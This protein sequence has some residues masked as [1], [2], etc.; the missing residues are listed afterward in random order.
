[1][2]LAVVTI[3]VFLALMSVSLTVVFALRSR[4]ATA[5]EGQVSLRRTR[6]VYDQTAPASVTGRLDRSFDRLV[7]ESGLGLT[8]VTAMLIALTA[9][10]LVGGLLLVIRGD[11]AFGAVGGLIGMLLPIGFFSFKR[12]RRMR[13]MEDQLPDAIDT[14]ARAVHAGETLEE[15]IS[16]VATE[17]IDPLKA[18][19]LWCCRQ[20]ELGLPVSSV[21][22][23]LSRRCQSLG[24]RT[25]ASTLAVHRQTGGNLA[26]TLERLA[27]VVRSRMAFQRQLRASTGAGKL[28]A[29][30]IAVA[31][32]L[33]FVILFL[34]HPD[35]IRML[36]D[37]SAGRIMLTISIILEVVGIA[38]LWRVM[39]VEV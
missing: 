34:V 30:M 24:I 15:A 7:L 11:V 14:M 12:S 6:N 38:W 19:F 23:G 4:L 18:E 26:T 1:V 31:A 9:G 10:L 36:L 37:S 33:V 2:Q 3:V 25:L 17:S 5:G 35:H 20:L 13:Q 27:E 28:S 22:G 21:M 16:L 32:P 29:Q 39:R 8:S